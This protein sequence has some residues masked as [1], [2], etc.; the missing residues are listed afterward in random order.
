MQTLLDSRGFFYTPH[1]LPNPPPFLSNGILLSIFPLQDMSRG[2]LVARGMAQGLPTSH[3]AGL[4]FW[5]RKYICGPISKPMLPTTDGPLASSA[6]KIRT[7]MPETR[8]ATLVLEHNDAITY[9]YTFA[10]IES[11]S[12]RASRRQTVLSE[13]SEIR[14]RG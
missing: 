7:S 6:N 10:R 5:W 11:F 13:L 8:I 3:G 4:L 12:A 9:Y 1:M 2:K 14:W